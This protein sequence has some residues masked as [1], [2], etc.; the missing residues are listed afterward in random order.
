MKNKMIPIE[1]LYELTTFVPFTLKWEKIRVSLRF[2][3]F[4]FKIMEKALKS[5]IIISRKVGF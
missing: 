3:L 5:W 2:D 1:I 4:I